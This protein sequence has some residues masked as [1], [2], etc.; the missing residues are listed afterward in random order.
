MSFDSDITIIGGGLNGPALALALA[1]GGFSV[2]LIDA[3]K[4]AA[5]GKAG[6]DGRAYALAL[7]SQRL[8]SVIG[9]WGDVRKNVEPILEVSI[10]DGT[11]EQGPGPWG[12]HFHHAEI[13]EGQVGVVVEDRFL[14]RALNKAISAHSRITHLKAETVVD[15]AVEPGSCTVTLKSGATITSRLI[16]GADG[17]NSG[18]ARRAGIKRQG[19]GYDQT[20]LVCALSVEQPHDGIAY[21][22]FLP[23]GPL[24]ILPLPENKVSIV[25]VEDTETADQISDMSDAQYLDVLRPRFGDFLGKIK[26]AGQTVQLSAEPV[27]GGSV[28]TV[29]HRSDR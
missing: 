13:D 27:T 22:Y 28:C 17:R 6:F 5:R 16:V 9:V 2:T 26:L 3:A 10:S 23:P 24:A 4:P 21:Q 8:L 20:A 7:A 29:A 18:T 1:D 12:L 25:W 15:Q 14:S 11:V 19:W